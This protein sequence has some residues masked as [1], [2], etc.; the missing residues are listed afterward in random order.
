M[1]AKKVQ[2]VIVNKSVISS[3]AFMVLLLIILKVTNNIEISW[4]WVLAPYWLPF[5]IIFGFI[6][7]IFGFIGIYLI[8]ALLVGLFILS[9]DSYENYKDK[10]RRLK[11]KKDI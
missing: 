10:K 6:G 9:L 2:Q 1:D 11:N 7:I 5:A 4:L 8:G 3:A